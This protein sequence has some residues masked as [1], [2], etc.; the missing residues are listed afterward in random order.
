MKVYSAV[1]E[2]ESPLLITGMKHGRVLEHHVDYIPGQ[3]IRGAFLTLL[4]LEG[5]KSVDEEISEP[6]I[7]F[8]PAYPA[9]SDGVVRPADPLTYRCKVCNEIV[10]LELPEDPSNLTIPVH[11]SK[12]HLYTLESIGG[13]LVKIS[14]KI[15]KFQAPRVMLESIGINRYLRS[16]EVGMLYSYIA[17]APGLKFTS[18]IVDPKD[19][20]RGMVEE[21]GL[22]INRLHLRM[23]RR[24]SAGLGHMKAEVREEK[25]YIER[26][27]KEIAGL[28]GKVCLLA[29]SPL[30]NLGFRDGRIVTTAKLGGEAFTV[31]FILKT[32]LVRV[33]GYSIR[34]NT[35]KPM[36]SGLGVGSLVVLENFNLNQL[37]TAEL[38]GVGPFSMAGLNIVE[39][40]G[41]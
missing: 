24:T 34:S 16:S 30:F 15:S 20:L 28:K 25:N 3:T 39:V 14:D 18:L 26:R 13:S 8:H 11:C 31:K 21:A 27:A 23:G 1:F 33:S 29:K 6:S 35:P 2:L 7:V 22:K 38:L 32:G 10:R 19:R 17:L 36:F 12:K 40:V 37:V 41:R 9:P 4:K 5:A